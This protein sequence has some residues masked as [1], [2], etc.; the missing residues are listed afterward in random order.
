MMRLAARVNLERAV[1]S[2]PAANSGRA[3]IHYPEEGS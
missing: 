2:S 3:C 1:I